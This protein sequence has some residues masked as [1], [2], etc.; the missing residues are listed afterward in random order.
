MDTK[1]QKI[2]ILYL[3]EYI[4]VPI[5]V[6]AFCYLLCYCFFRH[7]GTGAV[8]TTMVPSILAIVWWV[9]GGVLFFKHK[10]KAFERSFEKDGYA[11]NQTFYGRGQVVILDI[12]KGTMGLIFFWNPFDT[13]IL[14]ASRINSTLVDTGRS[15]SGIMEGSSRVSFLFTIDNNINVRVNTFMSNQRFNMNDNRIQTGIAKAEHMVRCIDEARANAD[16]LNRTN[17]KA[18]KTD[19]KSSSKSDTKADKSEKSAKT[20]KKSA[21]KTAKKPK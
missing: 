1:I 21:E 16:K 5:L 20:D 17:I 13:Y 9:F 14:P 4:F 10:V 6:C 15:G 12:A 8:I 11:R 18:A 3:L 7:G 2:N 19:T